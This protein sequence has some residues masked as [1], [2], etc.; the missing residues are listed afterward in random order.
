MLTYRSKLLKFVAEGVAIAVPAG[1]L[2]RRYPQP[3]WVVIFVA[4]AVVL[5]SAALSGVP[6]IFR[7]V[8]PNPDTA[9]PQRPVWVPEASSDVMPRFGSRRWA[10]LMF[11]NGIITIEELSGFYSQNPEDMADADR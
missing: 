3:E 5:A 10:R 4:L 11:H 7:H 1:L 8:T 2:L 6:P 9:P